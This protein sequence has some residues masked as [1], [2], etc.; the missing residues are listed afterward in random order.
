MPVL[1]LIVPRVPDEQ[2]PGRIADTRGCEGR[3]LAG[4]ALS[5]RHQSGGRVPKYDRSRF[6]YST[7]RIGEGLFVKFRDDAGDPSS[8]NRASSVRIVFAMAS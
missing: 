2:A 6:F 3:W 8:K 4:S 5:G 7:G 1:C